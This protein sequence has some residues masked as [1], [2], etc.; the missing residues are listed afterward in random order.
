MPIY[1]QIIRVVLHCKSF[2]QP[3]IICCGGAKCTRRTA[4]VD[5]RAHVRSA[6]AVIDIIYRHKS[7][8]NLVAGRGLRKKPHTHTRMRAHTHTRIE[9]ARANTARKRTSEPA[10]AQSGRGERVPR[11]RT[12][13]AV[14]EPKTGHGG[15][16]MSFVLLLVLSRYFY[17]HKTT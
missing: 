11:D 3:I 13:R 2:A 15:I 1:I 10:M 6:H 7:S 14:F 8:I 5:A 17:S 9:R 12:E 16:A 4:L